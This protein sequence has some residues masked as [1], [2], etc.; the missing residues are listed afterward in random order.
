MVRRGLSLEGLKWRFEM[1]VPLAIASTIISAVGK[2]QE[3]KAQKDAAKYRAAVS[4]NNKIIADRQATDALARGKSR[5]LT[6]RRQLETLKGKQRSVFSASG[7][8]VDE[9]APLD[10][11]GETAELG[12]IDA[13]AIRHGAA[14]EAHGFKTQGANF[15]AQSRLE[16]SQA[17]NLNP[18]FSAGA[19]LLTQGT[20]TAARFGFGPTATRT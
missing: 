10:I 18:L 13:L 17:N 8:T 1:G 7:V 20:S 5:E 15:E 19:T 16:E 14:T 2:F 12:E 9:E 3:V 6:F 11:L 4:R